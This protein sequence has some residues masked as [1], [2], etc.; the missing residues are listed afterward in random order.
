MGL[1]LQ[2][3]IQG[4]QESVE[5]H[6]ACT[7]RMRKSYTEEKELCCDIYHLGKQSVYSNS[8]PTSPS[9][10]GRRRYQCL[11]WSTVPIFPR[12]LLVT[13]TH[14]PLPLRLCLLLSCSLR[15][16]GRLSLSR[17]CPPHMRRTVEIRISN[18]TD[19]MTVSS[20]SRWRA[21]FALNVEC[22]EG[23]MVILRTRHQSSRCRAIPGLFVRFSP[24]LGFAL[25]FFSPLSR[26]RPVLTK[27]YK[28]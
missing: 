28:Y 19:C 24:L 1:E 11:A 2:I 8:I 10:S 22:A 13:A 6:A 27:E 3:Q 25:P 16:S 4:V 20:R 15:S 14:F 7:S 12:P 17:K 21:A 5:L 9:I 26:G 18:L 23:S